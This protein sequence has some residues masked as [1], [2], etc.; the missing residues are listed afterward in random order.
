MEKKEKLLLEK[1]ISDVAFKIKAHG[2]ACEVYLG[3]KYPDIVRD[4]AKKNGLF[5]EEGF[6][7]YWRFSLL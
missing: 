4:L 7:G 6:F 5:A 1:E 2:Y 3:H